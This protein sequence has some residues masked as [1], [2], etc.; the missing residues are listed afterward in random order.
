MILFIYLW[1]RWVFIAMQ[2]LSLIVASRDFFLVEMHRLLIVVV[3][4]V[5]QLELKGILV[6]VAAG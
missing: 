5:A 3:S 2:G 4:A 1:L 6:S